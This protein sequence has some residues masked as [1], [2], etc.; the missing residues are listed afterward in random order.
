VSGQVAVIKTLAETELREVTRLEAPEIFGEMSVFNGQPRIATVEALSQCVM[1][2]VERADLRPLI[3]GDPALVDQLAKIINKRMAELLK[4]SP[5][6]K[7]NQSNDL[8]HK[9][10]RLFLGI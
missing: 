9:M 5:E 3:E 4:L 10:R 8:I 6:S 1:L 7:L 2:E